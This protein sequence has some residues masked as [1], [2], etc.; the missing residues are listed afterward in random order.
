MPLY[1]YKCVEC[2]AQLEVLVRHPD[3]VTGK[4]D[5][6]VVCPKSECAGE[7]KRMLSRSTTFILKGGGWASDGYT[8]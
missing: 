6:V 4:H 3:L 5:E 2:G 7:A 8:G 1:E